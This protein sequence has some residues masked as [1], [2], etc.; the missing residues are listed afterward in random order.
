[1]AKSDWL[2]LSPTSGFGN[3]TIQNIGTTHTGRLDRQ[4][5]VTGRAIGIVGTKTYTVTQRAKSEFVEISEASYSIGYEGGLLTISGTANS[6]KLT[7]TVESGATLGAFMVNGAEAVNGENIAGDPG[8]YDQYNW[9]IQL[10]IAENLTSTSKSIFV[11]VNGVEE[12]VFNDVQIVQEASAFT[13]EFS[14]EASENALPASG[15]ETVITGLLKTYRNGSLLSSRTVTPVLS[16]DEEWYSINGSTVSVDSRGTVLGEARTFE[17]QGTYETDETGE[18]LNATIQISQAENTR[19]IVY[20]KPNIVSVNAE[21]IPASGGSVSSAEVEYSQSRHYYY[22]SGA[23]E[24][25]EALT[26]GGVVDFGDPVTAES[27]GTVLGGR[28]IVG[29]LTFTVSMNG[30]TSVEDTVAIYQQANEITDNSG[31]VLANIPG[32]WNANPAGENIYFYWRGQSIPDDAPQ[33]SATVEFTS[34]A[35]LNALLNNGEISLSPDTPQA[36][37]AT[38]NPVSGGAAQY[39]IVVKANPENGTNA[40]RNVAYGLTFE[41][42]LY[43]PDGSVNYGIHL[44]REFTLNIHQE[45]DPISE[46]VRWSA[47]EGS[48]PFTFKYNNIAAIGGTVRPVFSGQAVLIGKYEHAGSE[49]VVA[50]VAAGADGELSITPLFDIAA[51]ADYTYEGSGVDPEDGA[52]SAPTKG[53]AVS[54]ITVVTTSTLR[55]HIDGV[56]DYTV[57]SAVKQAAN[58]VTYGEVSLVVQTPISCDVTGGEYKISPIASQT[59]T[60]SSGSSRS[61]S[62][63]FQFTQQSAMSGFTLAGDKVNVTENT[64]TSAREGYTVVVTAKGEGS[65]TASKNVV[66]NQSAGVRTYATPQI[67][68]FTYPVI[69]AAGGTVTP[70]VTYKQTWG[71]NGETSGG[72]EITTGAALS[73]SGTGVAS[74]GAV[75]AGSKGTTVSGQTKVTDATVTVTLNN[76]KATSTVAVNQAANSATYGAVSISGGSVADIPASGGSVSS[77]SGISAA[78]TVSFTSGQSRAGSVSI[79][80]STAVSAGSLGTTVKAR[81][82]VG[83]LTAT[84]RGEGSKT[85]SKAFD[86]YQQANSAT[87]GNVTISGGSVSDIPASGGTVSSMSGISAAQTVSFT[88]GQSRAGSV[89]I[90]YSAAVTA[91]SLGTTVKNRTQVGTLTATATGEGSKT[92]TKSLTVYQAANTVSYSYG[93][94]SVS[95]SNVGDIPASGGTKSSCTISYSQVRTNSYTSGSSTTTTL[96]TGGSVSWGTAVSAGSLGTTVKSRTQVGTLKATVTMNSKSGSGSIAVY[97]QANAATSIT[98]GTPVISTFTVADIPASGGTISSASSL[99]YS[100][101]RTQNYTSGSTAAL[102]ALTSGL[103]V[104]YSTA[105]SAGSKGTTVS[106]RTDTGKDLTVTVSGN[107]KSATKSASVYQAKNDRYDNGISYGTWSISVTANRYTTSGSPCPASGGTCTITR[108][109]TRTRTQKYRYDSGSTSTAALSNESGTPTLSI[110]GTGASLS[111]T[112]VTWATRGST[113]GEVRSA[114]V[115]ATIGGVSATEVVYQQANSVSTEYGAWSISLSLDR[116]STTASPCP[117]SGGTATVTRSASRT[118]TSVYTSGTRV[119][120]TNESGTPTLSISGTGASLSGTTVTWA[121]RGTT[122]GVIRQATITASIGDKTASVHSYQQ[123]NTAVDEY[124]LQNLDNNDV[125]EIASEEAV[126]GVTIYEMNYY[127]ITSDQHRFEF[128][129]VSRLKYTSGGVSSWGSIY[130][131]TLFRTTAPS[132]AWITGVQLAVQGV[133]LVN[134]AENLTGSTRRGYILMSSADASVPL[135]FRIYFTQPTATALASTLNFSGVNASQGGSLTTA[136]GSWQIT[137]KFTINDTSTANYTVTASAVKTGKLTFGNGTDSIPLSSSYRIKLKSIV[138][139]PP[140]YTPVQRMACQFSF[141]IKCGN[142][143]RIV[144]GAPVAVYGGDATYTD[145]AG[146]VGTVTQASMKTITVT[147]NFMPYNTI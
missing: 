39:E 46:L 97:Q 80:Y 54:D 120:Q 126:S 6:Q 43:S 74:S 26:S 32:T 33:F 42:D 55:L 142:Y 52:V 49:V 13:Y 68:S 1:M 71:W 88:S 16:G 37:W 104:S 117:A 141:T 31:I 40:D 135:A 77:A 34:G 138:F 94:P 133:G 30:Q 132:G 90:S 9:S 111:G 99:V 118:R 96:T 47:T 137:F 21:D 2:T 145:S 93:T 58:G 102:S 59:V 35:S 23:T 136:N 134:V 44:S 121:S 127:S 108:S 65:K 125:I 70:T 8:A 76:I 110:S 83:T 29:Q 50:T 115:T 101:S 78:Q 92:A 139:S 4:T 25:L 105:V 48:A 45:L 116:Y 41:C 89:S 24:E 5:V 57:S 131:D 87:Y 28:E 7:I 27:R 62:I 91:G 63:T 130:Q 107:G 112:T 81:T 72:G 75:S 15:G 113:V 69:S 17:L 128:G 85:A 146:T 140:G 56:D 51:G 18:E 3:R 114:T 20:S 103:S 19:V 67:L 95:L 86:V 144:N 98:Y 129:V 82:K 22:D 38:L 143:S 79:S 66:F 100:Q 11:T 73:F 84:A 60:Y 124:A 122:A 106:A 147:G 10:Q 61:G 109:A 64:S 12:G 123:A 119:A 53:T 14:L 36:N